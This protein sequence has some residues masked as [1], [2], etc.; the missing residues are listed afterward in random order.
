MHGSGPCP[1]IHG[2]EPNAAV[3][4]QRPGFHARSEE[5][6]PAGEHRHPGRAHTVARFDRGGVRVDVI[7]PKGEPQTT[8]LWFLW[9]DGAL[10]FSLVGG[11]QKL[12]N[13]R[14][15]PRASVVIV[16]PAE[17]TYYVELR[18]AVDLVPT[19]SWS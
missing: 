9:R 19:P 10:R 5:Y 3:A 11:R 13:L 14:R 18:G 1:R 12:R 2:R 8:P 17:P 6:D 7:G 15:D 16:D 4:V